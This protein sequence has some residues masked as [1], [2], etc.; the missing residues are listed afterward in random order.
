MVL[1]IVEKPDKPANLVSDLLTE[2]ADRWENV[3]R[4][5]VDLASSRLTC[6][7]SPHHH[8]LVKKE[9]NEA[10]V[11]VH[12]LS[13]Q[14]AAG[15]AALPHSILE[16]CPRERKALPLFRKQLTPALHRR[17][18]PLETADLFR[19]TLLFCP[20]LLDRLLEISHSF[21]S[22]LVGDLRTRRQ[23]SLGLNNSYWR[24]IVSN[25]IAGPKH[26]SDGNRE[27]KKENPRQYAARS[28]WLAV[29]AITWGEVANPASKPT[30][31]D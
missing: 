26:C 15:W 17:Y 12:A 28:S 19:D 22:R 9:R 4:R 2:P 8:L 3:L 20:K 31:I 21:S 13:W 30:T 6:R 24:G 27:K 29:D 14:V 25:T 1:G 18:L 16:G 7:S 23:F 5:N 10:A 11:I